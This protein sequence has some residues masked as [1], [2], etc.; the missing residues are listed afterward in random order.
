MFLRIYKFLDQIM[1]F[2]LEMLLRYLSG[3]FSCSFLEENGF[4]LSDAVATRQFTRGGRRREATGTSLS[5]KPEPSRKPQPQRIKAIDKRPKPRG[6][7]GRNE[8]SSLEPELEP[9]LGSVF[10]IGSKKQSLNHLLNFSFA[11]RDYQHQG[12]R[13]RDGGKGTK[14]KLLSTK[15]HKYNKEH[16]LQAKLV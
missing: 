2:C 1:R 7:V 6:A 16:F 15:K 8:A 14:G 10:N 5:T 12:E 13:G 3:F 9:E 11:S 4:C